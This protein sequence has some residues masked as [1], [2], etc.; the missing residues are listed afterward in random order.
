[1][2]TLYII[3]ALVWTGNEV[4]FDVNVLPGLT[5][6]GRRPRAE[7][8]VHVLAWYKLKSWSQSGV[9][10]HAG[11]ICTCGGFISHHRPWLYIL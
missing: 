8:P 10:I 1:M 2:H 7:Q 9:F 11:N 5:V 4:C 3:L 6:A